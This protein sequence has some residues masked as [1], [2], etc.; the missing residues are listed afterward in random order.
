MLRNKPRL[1]YSGLTIVL[2]NP[3]RFDKT[4]LLTASAGALF[5]NFCLRPEFNSMQCDIRVSEDKSSF[6]EGTKCLMLLG[7]RSL[8][9]WLPECL[10]KSLNECR[11]GVYY[12]QGIPTIPSFYPQDAADIGKHEQHFNPLDKEYDPGSDD[13]EKEDSDSDSEKTL[14]RT[15]RSN[16]AFWLRADT[17][18]CKRIIKFGLSIT[19]TIQPVYITYPRL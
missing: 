6:I 8:Y 12:I 5:N 15:R 11:G 10:N 9:D 1:K 13:Y 16:Y 17:N 18:K 14:G 3:S 2:S 19:R 7:E 4:S